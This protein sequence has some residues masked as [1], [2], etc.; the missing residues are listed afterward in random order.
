MALFSFQDHKEDF[1]KKM[2]MIMLLSVS[3]QAGELR[4]FTSEVRANCD[5]SNR[6][7]LT[8]GHNMNSAKAQRLMSCHQAIVVHELLEEK[9]RINTSPYDSENSCLGKTARVSSAIRCGED[10]GPYTVFVEDLGGDTTEAVASAF[11]QAKTICKGEVQRLTE[12][13]IKRN[14]YN[15]YGDRVFVYKA[16]ATFECL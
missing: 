14:N 5:E 13:E 1:M 2:W 6:G 4:V 8:I 3:A 12:W 9:V 16:A 15:Y 11:Q 10:A 7:L